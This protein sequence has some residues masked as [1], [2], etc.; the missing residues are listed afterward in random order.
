MSDGIL[1][2]SAGVAGAALHGEVS[3]GREGL[4]NV[5]FARASNLP[6]KSLRSA[7]IFAFPAGSMSSPGID[8]HFCKPSISNR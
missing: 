6:C 3:G 1:E 7:S 5:F 8:L 4:S 2:G